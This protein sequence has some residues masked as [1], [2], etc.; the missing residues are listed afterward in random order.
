[1]LPEWSKFA[2]D[3]SYSFSSV[4]KT[5][6]SSNY[7]FKMNR[8]QTYIYQPMDFGAEILSGRPS[9]CGQKLE[10]RVRKLPISKIWM[11]ILSQISLART[12]THTEVRLV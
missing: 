2:Y 10:K 1:M 8:L 11:P 4:A 12:C 9:N 5:V 7:S 6:H 3:T